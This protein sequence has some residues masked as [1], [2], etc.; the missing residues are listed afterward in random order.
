MN[1]GIAGFKARHN[2]LGRIELEHPTKV[3]SKVRLT[4]LYNEK[5]AGAVEL[6]PTIA[7]TET[8]NSR[9]DLAKYAP[10]LKALA[11]LNSKEPLRD[12]AAIVSSH[13][14]APTEIALMR[15]EISHCFEGNASVEVESK[16]RAKPGLSRAVIGVGLC[17]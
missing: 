13:T 14:S 9:P 8:D 10:L 17:D 3:D 1:Q 11:G 4:T 16:P 12:V 15:K 5:V 7:L 2:P 6:N